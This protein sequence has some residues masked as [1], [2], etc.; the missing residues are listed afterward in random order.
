MSQLFIQ[1]LREAPGDAE[2]ASHRLLL[3]AGF[4]RQ[5]ASGIFCYLPL[6]R[7][8]MDRIEG[9]IRQEMNAIGGQ[10]ITMPVV[11]P[12]DIWKQ[13]GRWYEVGPEMGRFQDKSGR[14]MVLAMTHE[15]VA[16]F[17]VSHQIQSY[18]QLPQLIYHI[19]TKWRDDPRPRSGLIRVR[20]FTMKDSYSLDADWEGLEVQYRNHYQAYFNVFS[21][22][23]LDTIA[24]RSD[25]GMMGGRAA[26][27]F[28]YL[29]PIGEDTLILCSHCGYAANRQVATFRRAPA[30]AEEA[31]PLERVATPGAT[32]IEDLARFLGV[33]AS[34]TAKAV[35]LVARLSQDGQDVDRFVLAVI[36]GDLEI[37][38]TKLANALGARQLRPAHDEEIAATGA[39][40]GYGSPIGVRDALV[41]VD[42]SIPGSPN[43]V[44]GANQAGY[45]LRN[46]NYGRDFTAATVCDLAAAAGGYPCPQCGQLLDAQRGIEVGNIFQL[47][48]KYTLALGGNFL[49][50]A[51]RS[52]P[53]VMGSYGIGVGRLLA[54]IAE[55][56]HDDQGLIWPISVAP[57]QVHLVSL[58]K[59]PGPAQEA[60]D[61]LYADL[62]AAGLEVLLDDRDENPGVKFND[63]D[64]IGIPVR[65]NLGERSLKNGAVELKLRA[66][67]ERAEVPLGEAVARVVSEVARLRQELEA[68]ARTV[69]YPG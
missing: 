26:H 53:V 49:D 12:A 50:A 13:T 14:D 60:A 8:S 10:E 37:N 18:R 51:G 1:T 19:Q 9:I 20:E 48:T 44:A 30:A 5:L 15:E 29:N 21:R 27:E 22:C 3:R 41:V 7:R 11:H 4:I 66:A 52:R 47:G 54:C 45:H 61:R 69:E 33:P 2:V 17:L 28:M 67:R 35:F 6:A 16:A 36:R 63:A 40:P 31:A 65:L 59:K 42:E 62:Q 56:H 58:A 24:V 64:L 34:R 57:F 38:E 23:G 55:E 46:V 25:V 68:R 43:L 32:T 39:V